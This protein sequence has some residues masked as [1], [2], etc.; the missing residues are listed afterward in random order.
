MQT[1]KESSFLLLGHVG[2]MS[3]LCSLLLTPPWQA[4]F[5]KENM[6]LFQLH[7]YTSKYGSDLISCVL[8]IFDFNKG[9]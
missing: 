5:S 9:G 8:N 1:L 7:V 6:S 2:I 3:F 4:V